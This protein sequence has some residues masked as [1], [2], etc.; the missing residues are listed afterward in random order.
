VVET[1]ETAWW[2]RGVRLLPPRFS[3]SWEIYASLL[4]LGFFILG[5]PVAEPWAVVVA[6]VALA[7]FLVLFFWAYWLSGV[8]VLLPAAGMVAI[9]LGLLPSN[10]GASAFLGYAV[11]ICCLQ[12]PA[13]WSVPVSVGILA[14]FLMGAG[15]AGY[16]PNYLA[17]NS[18]VIVAVAAI[19]I[20]VRRSESVTARLRLREEELAF[21]HKRAERRRIAHDLHDHL[22]SALSL[23]AVK[24]ELARRLGGEGIAGVRDELSDIAA[25]SRATLNDVRQVIGDYRATAFE[26]ELQRAI[27]LL[28]SNGLTVDVDVAGALG[29]DAKSENMLAM[30]L[31]EAAT[32]VARHAR[33]DTCSIKTEPRAGGFRLVIADNGC[34]ARDYDGLGVR[35]MRERALQ[36]GASF[37]IARANGTVVTV[38][39]PVSS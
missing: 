2:R 1:T 27:V 26:G 16:D 32:N 37:S 22:G 14:T 20:Q 36:I 9:G 34:G 18:L 15:F 7:V 28:R 24:A 31:C 21:V 29:V 12:L 13:S 30:I 3:Q 11:A 33:A 4:F 17:I 25:T 35:G 23:I 10:G 8:R 39:V 38:D 19:Y 5:V 6:A